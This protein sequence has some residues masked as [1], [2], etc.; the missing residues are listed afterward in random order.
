MLTW[1]FV[2]SVVLGLVGWMAAYWL[3]IG[4][5]RRARGWGA[6]VPRFQQGAFYLGTLCALAAL[7]SPLD[8]LGDSS[9]FS[10]HMAQHMLLIFAAAPLWLAGTPGWLVHRLVPRRVRRLLSHPLVAFAIYNGVVWA[11]HIPASYDRALQIE[12]LHIFE[13]LTFLA[14]AVIGWWPVLG[15][16]LENELSAPLK[17]AYLIPSLFSCTALAALITLAP[18]QL[19]PFYGSAAT[20]WGLAP[21]VDQQIGGLLMWLPGDMIYLFLIVWT[22]NRLIDQSDLEQPLVNL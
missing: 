11:W 1:N 16:G 13:H 6:A 17:L 15:S 19:Y 22:V 7:T 18:I 14:A 4:P 3:A 2:P 10:A 12:A 21:L 8:T 9:L 5:M 20:S